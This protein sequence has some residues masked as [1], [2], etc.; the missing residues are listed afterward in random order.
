MATDLN[1]RH[2]RA[3]SLHEAGQ[4]AEALR[5]L[6]R[7]RAEND[8]PSAVFLGWLCETGKAGGPP[9]PARARANYRMAADRGDAVGQYYLGSFLFR[10]GEVTEAIHELQRAAE[11]GYGPALYALGMLHAS[12]RSV[13][14]DEDEAFRCMTR[15]ADAGHPFAQRWLAVRFLMGRSGLRGFFRGLWW[16][17]CVP[18]LA[19]RLVSDESTDPNLL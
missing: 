17:V 6:E 15:A 14:Q 9:D 8:A 5:E 1:D 19:F 13:A 12:G 10:Q 18:R 4:V 11:Q 7:L 2:R 3:R 16:F